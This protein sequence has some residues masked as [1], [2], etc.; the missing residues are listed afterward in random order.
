MIPAYSLTPSGC[1]NELT[2][3][4]TMSDG[5]IPPSQFTF[6][7]TSSTPEINVFTTILTLTGVYN[8]KVS[9]TDPKTGT[10]DSN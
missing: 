8:L 9:V 6:T 3:E 10:L 4:V 1:P 2:Y 5:S 7:E